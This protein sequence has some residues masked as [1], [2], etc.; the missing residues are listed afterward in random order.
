MFRAYRKKR[1]CELFLIQNILFIMHTHS[2]VANCLKFL[3]L[4]KL[5]YMIAFMQW[6]TE[7]MEL[8]LLPTWKQNFD[9]YF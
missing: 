6:F 7:V 5:F 4:V 8:F 2:L 3:T 1:F 9:L